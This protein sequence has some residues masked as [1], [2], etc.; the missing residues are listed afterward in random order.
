M[1]KQKE[2]SEEG[3]G[4]GWGGKEEGG[5]YVPGWAQGPSEMPLKYLC[6]LN[7][8]ATEAPSSDSVPQAPS[9]TPKDR[10]SVPPIGQAHACRKERSGWEQAASLSPR[11]QP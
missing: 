6:C 4:H 7:W 2:I 9:L 8:A 1:S 3:S 10:S 11:S 5:S